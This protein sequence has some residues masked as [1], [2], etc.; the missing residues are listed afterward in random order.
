MFL[1]LHVNFLVVQ[2]LL[3]RSLLIKTKI[4]STSAG[5]WRLSCCGR[6]SFP[7]WAA[8]GQPMGQEIWN[9]RPGQSWWSQIPW[10]TTELQNHYCTL[11]F[12]WVKLYTA[13]IDGEFVKANMVPLKY[14]FGE[15]PNKLYGLCQPTVRLILLTIITLVPLM[16][17]SFCSVQRLCWAVC[18]FQP[19]TGPSLLVKARS[20][21]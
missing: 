5:Q 9:Q 11:C 10:F 18:P 20:L 7:L 3:V 13:V 6:S 14:L 1:V 16:T 2:E 17:P 4:C 21:L 8:S 19:H 12:F 15:N